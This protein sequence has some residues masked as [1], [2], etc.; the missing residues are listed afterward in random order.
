[1]IDDITVKLTKQEVQAL[2]TA[3]RNVPY[4]KCNFQGK[5]ELIEKLKGKSNRMYRNKY[6]IEEETTNEN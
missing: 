1:M 4:G 5:E 6:N 3:L 2:I